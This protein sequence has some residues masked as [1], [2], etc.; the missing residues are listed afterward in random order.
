MLN[1][2]YEENK[3]T[4]VSMGIL[5]KFHMGRSIVLQ[6]MVVKELCEKNI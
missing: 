5:H 2:S 1:K 6:F 4:C 3:Y